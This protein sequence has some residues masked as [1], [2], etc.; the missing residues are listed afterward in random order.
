MADNPRAPRCNECG[1]QMIRDVRT[2]VDGRPARWYCP[3]PER[4][5]DKC[6]EQSVD[7]SASND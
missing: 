3:T 4:H 2:L 6:N 5:K 7:A 1:H